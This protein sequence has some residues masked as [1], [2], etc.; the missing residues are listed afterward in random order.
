[1]STKLMEQ[2]AR[3]ANAQ[4]Q[5]TINAP[6]ETV[7]NAWFDHTADWFY[8]SEETKTSHPTICEKRIGGKFYTDLP[9]DGFNVLGELTMIKPNNKI[10]IRGDCTMPF[11]VLMNITV[12]FEDADGGTCVSID[13]RMS[14]E[15]NDGM[16][17]EFEAGWLDGLEKLKTLLEA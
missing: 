5:I 17:E 9:D 1:M 4:T 3:N 15:I 13:H 11:A 14:G 2:Y 8:H 7:F 12:S 6:R 10:R 16:A